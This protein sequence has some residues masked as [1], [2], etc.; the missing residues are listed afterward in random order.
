MNTF[1]FGSQSQPNSVQFGNQSG[2]F[3][4]GQNI[5]Q[6]NTSSLQQST[7][8]NKTT[9]LPSN[10]QFGAQSNNP[11][12]AASNTL[13]GNLFNAGN[14]QAHL[15][16][17]S[18]NKSLFNSSSSGS[19]QVGFNFANQ[20]NGTGGIG[21]PMFGVGNQNPFQSSFNT[22]LQQQ[23]NSLSQS[24]VNFQPSSQQLT[25]SGLSM[26]GGPSTNSGRNIATARRKNRGRR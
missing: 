15:L 26:G 1:Q 4:F 24:K 10:I 8:A 13:Q 14:A 3:Q 2:S 25:P 6:T 23:S 11:M 19:P 18:G 12:P 22:P 16:N 20:L 9:G 21:S 7:S 17:Q 5:S